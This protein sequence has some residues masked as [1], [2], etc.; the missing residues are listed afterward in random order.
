M[1]LQYK[2]RFKTLIKDKTLIFWTLIFP[3][4]LSIFFQLTL[5]GAHK[6][7]KVETLNVILINKVEDDNFNKLLDVLENN[8]QI[9]K[10]QE[11]DN[12][13]NAT[14]ALEN[15]DVDAVIV[16]DGSA[17]LT[18]SESNPNN[19]ILG[20]LL[21]DF[22]V[23]KT[24][25]LDASINNPKLL[26]TNFIDELLESNNYFKPATS[27]NNEAVYVIYFYT[28]IAMMIIYASEWGTK[29]GD[30][31]MAGNTDVAI[32][33]NIAPTPKWKIMLIDISSVYT[34]YLIEFG[35]LY[36]FMRL[37]L[38][39]PFGSNQLVTI[40]TVISGGLFTITLGYAVSVFVKGD[41]QKK[42]T[43]ISM[44]GLTSCFLS[45]MMSVDI[46]HIVSRHF[47][48]IKY[49]NPATLI[50][51]NF[52]YMYYYEDLSRAFLNIFLM[53]CYTCVI[54]YITYRKLK[55]VSYDRI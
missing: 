27:R 53:V 29:S 39:V 34:I 52:Y 46:K 47:P 49:I 43:L 50:T 26:T 6:V 42:S 15:H 21:N 12:Y 19:T 32:R 48:I 14:S 25:I 54:G 23:K 8:E 7:T 5:V 17:K 38:K 55:V 10:V 13:E 18:V 33:A 20:V 3:I 22:N 41:M 9:I 44:M 36:A 28:A 51:D 1:K 11:G 40:L 16:Y 24:M 4:L 31:L 45:G 30:Y 2:Y 35:I 37:I